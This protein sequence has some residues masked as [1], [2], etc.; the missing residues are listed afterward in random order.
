MFI[1]H[2][3]YDMTMLC[4]SLYVSYDMTVLC[5]PLFEREVL[6]HITELGTVC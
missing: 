1:C 5:E 2:V 3:S 6:S 4:E